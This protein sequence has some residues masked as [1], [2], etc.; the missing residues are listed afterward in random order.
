MNQGRNEALASLIQLSQSK[1]YLL[2]D[3]I[4]NCTENFDLSI[5]DVNWLS[6][7]IVIRGTIVYDEKPVS[8]ITDDPDEYDD[9]AQTDYEAIFNKVIE[10][11]PSLEPFIEEVRQIVPPQFKEISKLKY[12]VVEGNQYA[13][14]RLIEMHIRVAV[15]IALQRAEAYDLDIEETIGDACV[16]LISAVEK[17]DPDTSGPFSSYASAWIFQNVTREQAT[18]RP[19]VYYPTHKKEQF[20][21]MYPI[22]KEYGCVG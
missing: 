17:Y 6:N 21:K 3:D 20:F 11:S 9:Y 18:Q 10:L 16:G 14:N 8:N 5:Q 19:L 4:L 7:E 15:R 1:G 22:L 2:F 13:R 12:Q